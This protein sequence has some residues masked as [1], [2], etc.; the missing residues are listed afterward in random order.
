MVYSPRAYPRRDID[1]PPPPPEQSKVTLLITPRLHGPYQG[2]LANN[3]SQKHLTFP[4][5]GILTRSQGGVTLHLGLNRGGG[6]I[7]YDVSPTR[8]PNIMRLP[9]GGPGS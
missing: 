2:P 1:I 8:D 6:D 9:N 3:G 4:I 7:T 5:S